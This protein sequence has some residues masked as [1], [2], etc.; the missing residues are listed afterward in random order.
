MKNFD[1]IDLIKITIRNTEFDD[2]TFVAGGWVR[3]RVR[4][5]ESNDIDIV[6]NLPNG[7]IKLAKFLAKKL[8]L[9]EPVIFHRFGT[10]QLVINEVEVEFVMSRKEFY[11]LRSRN[12]KVEFGSLKDDVFRRDFTINSMLFNVTNN[13]LLDLTGRGFCDINKEIIDTTS[14]PDSI[15]EEDSLRM[16]RAIRFSVKLNYKIVDRVQEAIE[17]NAHN[18]KF[19]SNERIRDEL[20]KMFKTD[21][22][23]SA[24]RL[25]VDCN[26]MKHVIPEVVN[27]IDIEQNKSHDNDVFEHTIDV[28]QKI[29]DRNLKDPL[30][31]I[32]GLFHDIGKPIAKTE[33]ENGIHFIKHDLHGAVLTKKI[34][35]RLKFSNTEIDIVM[36][37]VKDHMK[38]K[39]LMN[40][41]I[42][43]KTVRRLIRT[44]GDILERLLIL[45]DSDNKSHVKEFIDENQIEKVKQ[46]IKEIENEKEPIDLPI[47]GIDIMKEFKIK[48][49]S[50]VGKLLNQAEELFLDNP[51]IS[52]DDLLKCLQKIKIN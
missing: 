5:K 21:S 3:D 11:T 19:I 50:E 33:D 35:Q 8:N 48:P 31:I 46:I 12:P 15:F 52:K 10:A 32:A 13:E 30:L 44:S 43:K 6:V 37:L 17:R 22:P 36:Q 26:L 24:I 18:I 16:L 7:G 25:L 45:I 29:Q 4:K 49:G 9:R 51:N 39:P 20:V 23:V 47:N 40:K 41:D 27:L 42:P 1:P 14:D 2:K 38:L 28:V 34:M